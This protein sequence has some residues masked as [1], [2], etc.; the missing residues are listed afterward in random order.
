[1]LVYLN[2]LHVIHGLSELEMLEVFNSVG[3]TLLKETLEDRAV[4]LATPVTQ[5][6]LLKPS[7]RLRDDDT[8]VMTRNDL[9]KQKAAE[10]WNELLGPDE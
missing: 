3:T 10:T 9:G 7:R 2:R 6:Q 4:G 1:M 8:I 5:D